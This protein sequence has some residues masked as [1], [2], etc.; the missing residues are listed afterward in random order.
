MELINRNYNIPQPRCT[1]G[2]MG[3]EANQLI[4]EINV[5]SFA[6][7]PEEYQPSGTCNFSRADSVQIV[8]SSP[9]TIGTIYVR[10]Y[11]I[12]RIASGMG[13]LAFAN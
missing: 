10:N 11:N 12:L 9:L 13:G 5:Y 2:S 7:K 8:A 3:I 4:D 1:S 6:L